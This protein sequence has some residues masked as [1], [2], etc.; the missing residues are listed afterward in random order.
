MNTSRSKQDPSVSRGC[1]RQC[2]LSRADSV[3]Y[4]NH[5]GTLTTR[6]QVCFLVFIFLWVDCFGDLLLGFSG[7]S[8]N[9][10]MLTIPYRNHHGGLTARIQVG[11]Y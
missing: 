10:C 2:E 9:I 1:L 7:M 11:R 4:R 5:H 8:F 3:P 6:F